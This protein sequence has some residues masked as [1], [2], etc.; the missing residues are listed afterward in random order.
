LYNTF[1]KTDEEKELWFRAEMNYR[2]FK[3]LSYKLENSDIEN[4]ILNNQ[5][6]I[7][8]VSK[9]ANLNLSEVNQWLKNA[10]NTESVL[11][12]N[13]DIIENTN[14]SFCMQW[15]FPQAYYSVFGTTLAKFKAIGMTE[16]SHTSVLKKYGSLMLEGKLPESI[17]ISCN[18]IAKNLVFENI[19]VPKKIDSYMDLDLNNNAT[20]DNHICQFLKATRLLRLKEKAPNMGFKKPNGEKRKNLN[21]ELW[22]KVSNSIGNTT[23]F[24]F[25]YRKRIK[26]NYQDIETYNSSYFKGKEVLESLIS[27][28]DRIN[29]VNEVYTCKAIGKDN[30]NTFVERQLK[31]VQND[32]LTNRLRT[33]NLIIEAL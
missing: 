5:Y 4:E 1:P 33:T 32:K 11:I 15:A 3:S 2:Q 6:F 7:Q 19:D 21:D 10:W 23:I 9:S 16:S 8:K 27:V 22:T 17:S 12:R 30:Y 31:L 24:D 13:I 14:Q 20:I 26:G 18:G 28:I 25:L 29:M